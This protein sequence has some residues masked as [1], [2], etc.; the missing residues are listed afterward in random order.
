MYFTYFLSRLMCI[1][2]LTWRHLSLLICFSFEKETLSH[3]FSRHFQWPL[4]VLRAAYLGSLVFLASYKSL[5]S[6]FLNCSAQV[7]SLPSS[8]WKEGS[9]GKPSIRWTTTEA[10]WKFCLQNLF[11]R[12]SLFCS[13]S[14]CYDFSPKH[15]FSLSLLFSSSWFAKR[16]EVFPN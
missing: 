6:S 9:S 10:Y 11:F 1:K 3:I 5:F 2:E 15:A 7:T 14:S 8:F 4:R 13:L 16:N 12:K